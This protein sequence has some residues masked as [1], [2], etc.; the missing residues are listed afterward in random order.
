MSVTSFRGYLIDQRNHV[1][2]IVTIEAVDVAS[3][4]AQAET[5]LGQTRFAAIEV[6]DGA[7][8]VA[9]KSAPRRLKFPWPS[10]KHP[11]EIAGR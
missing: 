3:A 7:C 5:V 9:R 11:D 6:W 1:C 8:I 2:S 4:C 10:R